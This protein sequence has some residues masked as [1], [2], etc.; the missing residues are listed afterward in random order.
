[1]AENKICKVAQ[2]CGGCQLQSLDY[3]QQLA[4]KQKN[5]ENLFP[6]YR[7]EPI[8][9][10]RS[11]FNYRNKVQVAF[12]K[13]YR[14][15]VVCGNYVTSTHKI[16]DVVDCQITDKRA[17]KIIKTIKQL[18]ISFKMSIFDEESARGF[19][20]HVLVRTAKKEIMVVLVTGNYEFAKKR[21]FIKVLLEKHPEITTIVQSINS[22]F[23][24]MVLGD[25]FITLYGKGYITDELCSKQFKISANSFYQVNTYQTEVLYNTA[26]ALANLNKDDIVVDTYCGIGTISLAVSDKVKKVLAVEINKQ[27]IYDAIAN[28]KI[29]K[30]SN[31]EFTAMDAGKYMQQLAYN[32]QK[33]D[34]LIM[35]PA[36]SGADNKFLYAC[37]KL[38][39]SKIVYISCN[40]TTQK[41]NVNYLLKKGYRIEKIVPV[42]MFPFTQH[43]ETVCLLTRK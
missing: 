34:V 20:R 8:I 40:P 32:K 22:R 2:I 6:N 41:G 16:V 18:V 42:D 29:N 35:D 43:C 4:L 31:V 27:A 19:L 28:S 39:P 9:G 1:M 5:I 37:S 7:V 10:C 17:N 14:N 24:S 11:P 3:Q 38:L 26:I 13:D 33:I 25:K 21:D 23:T 36:R 15:R 30:I 12:G